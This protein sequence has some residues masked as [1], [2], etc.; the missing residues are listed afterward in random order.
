MSCWDGFEEWK[1]YTVSTQYLPYAFFAYNLWKVVY[2][3]PC[4]DL[5]HL[6]ENYTFI[7]L[8]RI[9]EQVLPLITYLFFKTNLKVYFMRVIC[10]P[11]K[12]NH[13]PRIYVS[14][15]NICSARAAAQRSDW[16]I[17]GDHVFL[18]ETSW[19]DQGGWI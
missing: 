3:L 8:Y 6:L 19:C 4:S 10:H 9:P 14:S 18:T 17:N 11:H 2:E 16:T 13:Y 1:Y 15:T 5:L 12:K 7:R